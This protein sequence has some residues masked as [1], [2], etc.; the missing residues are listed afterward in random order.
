M[1]CTH[2]RPKLCDGNKVQFGRCFGHWSNHFSI[3]LIICSWFLPFG[4][5]PPSPTWLTAPQGEVKVKGSV[6]LHF[7]TDFPQQAAGFFRPPARCVLSEWTNVCANCTAFSRMSGKLTPTNKKIHVQKRQ[8]N[9]LLLHWRQQVERQTKRI[10][11]LRGQSQKNN[12]GPGAFGC[13]DSLRLRVTNKWHSP[14]V[15]Q[16]LLQ[17]LN[18]YLVWFPE[19]IIPLPQVILKM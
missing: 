7:R 9:E 15:K 19:I 3:S 6:V 17:A 12:A 5:L 4:F 2:A 1:R 8:C 13:V 18:H 16:H 10:Q 14:Q 11:N